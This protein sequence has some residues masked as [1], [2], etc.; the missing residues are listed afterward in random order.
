MSAREARTEG[1]L[2]I[3]RRAVKDLLLAS[4]S[5]HELPDSERRDLA[6]AMVKVCRHATE[7][8]EEEIKS[9]AAY[10]RASPLALEAQGRERPLVS[11]AQAVEFGEAASRVGETTKQVLTAVSFPRFVT[12]LINGVFKAMVDSNQQQMQG[13][14]ELLRNVSATTDGFAD[15]NLGP[16]RAR[17]WLAEQYPGSFE[18]EEDEGDDAGWGDE[19]G[20]RAPSRRFRLILRSGAEWPPEGALRTDLGLAAD[21]SVSRGDP[22][23][24]LLPLARRALARQKQQMLASMV[25]MGLQRI[26]IESGRIH[27]SMRFHIDTRSALAEDRGS[28]FDFRNTIA[29]AGSYGFGPWGV[30]ASVQNTIGYVSTQRTQ[31]TEELNTEL[32]LNSSVEIVFRTDHVPLEVLAGKD[33]RDRI[34]V[35]TLN[36]DAELKSYREDSSARR[37]AATEAQT[38]RRT[39]L[40]SALKPPEHPKPILPETPKPMPEAAPAP[41]TTEMPDTATRT[42]E[43]APVPDASTEAPAAEPGGTSEGASPGLAL[44][45]ADE[46]GASL[47]PPDVIWVPTPMPGVAEMLEL[48]ELKPGEVLYDLGC[49]DGRIVITA[50]KTYGCRAI[51]FDIDPV[52]VRE[53]RRHVREAGVEDKVEIRHQDLFTVDLSGADVVT[54]YLLPELN[55]RLLP[56]LRRMKPGAR[57]VSHDFILGD[58]RPERMVQVYFAQRNH[59]RTF[60]RWRAPL[61]GSPVAHEQNKAHSPAA[62]ASSRPLTSLPSVTP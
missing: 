7:W 25:L 3:V 11:R 20:A 50:A 62:R 6:G 52:R 35:N 41:E 28:S 44:G 13:F 61:P 39:E 15:A 49:G 23:T 42:A 48:A 2:E 30:S 27:A 60:Y 10:R 57:I 45:S 31:T 47:R 29:A 40:G 18:L 16:D 19:E 32:D 14:V 5:F 58:I 17:A 54:L 21:E 53:S 59:F 38:A 22:E 56:Q 36:P 34:K 51:G 1:S 26:V 24:A 12:E 37:K 8:L 43:P 33:A 4:P 55:R 9:D 46:G